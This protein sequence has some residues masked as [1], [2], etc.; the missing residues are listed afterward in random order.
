MIVEGDDDEPFYERFLEGLGGEYEE[1]D[2]FVI[3][4]GIVIDLGKKRF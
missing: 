2:G 1:H 3:D 4:M